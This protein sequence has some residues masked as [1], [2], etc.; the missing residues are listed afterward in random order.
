[1]REKARSSLRPL[2]PTGRRVLWMGWLVG[3]MS[4]AASWNCGGAERPDRGSGGSL[5]GADSG[6]AAD[7]GSGGDGGDGGDGGT[8]ADSGSGGS[9][10]SGGTGTSGS[11][12]TGTSGS[13][14]T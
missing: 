6:A 3:L 9:S 11:G 5:A 8:G 10:G 14:G 1:M 2:V 4:A 7:G 12:G 13:G